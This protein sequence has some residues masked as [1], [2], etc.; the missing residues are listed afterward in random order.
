MDYSEGENE[1]IVNIYQLLS[2]LLL[3]MSENNKKLAA[4]LK[5]Q[6]GD[7]FGMFVDNYRET[8]KVLGG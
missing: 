8:N 3:K 7:P 5:N 1:R 6:V 4:R 2:N